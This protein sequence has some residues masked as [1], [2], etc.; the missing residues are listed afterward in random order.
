LVQDFDRRPELGAMT[1]A[2]LGGRSIPAN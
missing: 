1:F 2:I